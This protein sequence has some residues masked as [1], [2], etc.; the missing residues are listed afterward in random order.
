[1]KTNVTMEDLEFWRGTI[2]ESLKTQQTYHI[3]NQRKL[4]EI[5]DRLDGLSKKLEDDYIKKDMISSMLENMGTDHGR[6]ET[7][8]RRLDRLYNYGA[9]ILF[10]GGPL[11]G[12]V[13]TLIGNWLQR[14]FHIE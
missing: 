14:I 6:I 2:T 9:V 3:E 13:G 8:E 10:L 12:I 1:M 11:L 5:A 4:S 7:L